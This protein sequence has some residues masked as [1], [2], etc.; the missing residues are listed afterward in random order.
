MAWLLAPQLVLS[1]NPTTTYHSHVIGLFCLGVD[2]LKT[3]CPS[4]LC[5][6]YMATVN[7]KDCEQ[8]SEII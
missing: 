4:R 7:L 2:G 5:S 1:S 3:P 8:G 6:E